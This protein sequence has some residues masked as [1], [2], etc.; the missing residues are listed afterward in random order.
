MSV[1]VD[2]VYVF[3]YVEQMFSIVR[4]VYFK[5]FLRSLL[6]MI[7]TALA[8]LYGLYEFDRIPLTY[9][10]R[11]LT[12]TNTAHSLQK[13]MCV[14]GDKEILKLH[15]NE[16][17]TNVNGNDS[18]YCDHSWYIIAGKISPVNKNLMLIFN[19]SESTDVVES[20]DVTEGDEQTKCSTLSFISP[21][22]P[23]VA[24]AS[25][26]GSGNTWV[27]HLLQQATGGYP[28]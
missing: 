9:V 2:T 25:V 4:I 6:V 21:A 5:R 16:D 8:F 12:N 20:T 3:F 26:P 1:K 10:T 23:R 19:K 11:E 15:Q 24:L 28:V 7:I 27:R 17:E 18:F 14:L 13:E 22:G